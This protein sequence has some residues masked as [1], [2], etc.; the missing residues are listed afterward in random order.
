MIDFKLTRKTP[1]TICCTKTMSC[2]RNIEQKKNTMYHNQFEKCIFRLS[3][4][5]FILWSYVFG[6]RCFDLHS[7]DISPTKQHCQNYYSYILFQNKTFP[8]V[9]ST[10]PNEI[11]RYL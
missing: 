11:K 6:K 10:Q 1:Y 8:S 5:V 9:Y 7:Q 2:E 4:S 3:S